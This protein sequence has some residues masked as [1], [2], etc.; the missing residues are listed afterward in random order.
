MLVGPERQSLLEVISDPASR[1]SKLVRTTALG[2]A[3]IQ[4]AF[5]IFDELQ[6]ELRKRIGNNAADQLESSLS[7][8]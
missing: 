6:D 5:S 4:T 1:S 2:A 8:D 3:C 7:V